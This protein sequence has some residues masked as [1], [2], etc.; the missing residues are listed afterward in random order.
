MKTYKGFKK[1]MTCRDFQYEEGKEY[2][3]EGKVKACDSG[4][5]ACE[6]PIDCFS[7]YPPADSVYH[8]VEQDGEISKQGDDSKVAS[9]IIKIGGR[10]DV[11][12]IAKAHFEYV[13]A[14]TNF[15]H[16]DPKQATAGYRGAATAGD[17]GAATA[18][19]C[20]AATA[21]DRGAAT[22]GDCGAATAGDRGAA[23]AGDR[24]AATAG[25]RG[26]ATAGDRG[27]ATAGEYGAATSR[28]SS[29]VGINGIACARGDDCK[30]KGGLGAILVLAE[31]NTY[32]C[33]IKEWKV[34]VVDGE[35]IK[36]DVWYTLKNGEFAEA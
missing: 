27:A 17:R 13:K 14:R 12:G 8:E 21:G 3:H 34:E 32:N 15:E 9:S 4:F 24:G 20:G 5:H 35:R 36:P 31:E 30:V 26:A 16:T 19:Y 6:D 29:A 33:E 7:Y 25:D 28:G 18:G 22:A 10:L 2:H 11:L 23:T 1:D